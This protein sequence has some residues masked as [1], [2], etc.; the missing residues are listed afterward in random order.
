MRRPEATRGRQPTDKFGCTDLPTRSS[1]PDL[2]E[3]CRVRWS[4]PLADPKTYLAPLI[5]ELQKP[6]PKNRTVNVVCHGHSVP[7]GYFKTPVVQTFDAYPHLLHRRLKAQLP[8]AVLN[9]IVTAIGGE[10]SES[11]AARFEKDVLSLRPDLVTL[12]YA[13]NDR[14]LGLEKAER[15]WSQ[16]IEAAKSRGIKVILLTPTGDSSARWADPSDPLSRHAAQVRALAER[17]SV[18][19]ADSLAAFERYVLGG[20]KLTDLLSQVNH[21]SRLGHDLVV[22]ELLR[23]FPS[24]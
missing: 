24:V 14:A 22:G 9:V 5:A 19:L 23:W 18:A 3:S 20:G 21:P 1:P 4:M 11:G 8:H 13:L 10:N 17:H 6:W 2:R 15:A 12:D 7:A 16:M